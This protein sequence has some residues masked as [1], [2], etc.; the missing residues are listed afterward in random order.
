MTIKS[1]RIFSRRLRILLITVLLFI[2]IGLLYIWQKVYVYRTANRSVEIIDLRGKSFPELTHY[3]QSQS[4]KNGAV[5]AFSLLKQAM[6]PSNTDLHLL[7]HIIGDELYKQRG[8]EGIYEC[9]QDFRNAC[10]HSIVVGLYMEKAEAALPEISEIC[11]KA[12]GGSGAYTMCFHGLGHGVLAAVNYDM[13]QAVALCQKTGTPE[14]QYREAAECIGGAVMEIISGGSH[15]QKAWA[16]Q[17]KKY[18]DTADMLTPCSAEYIPD[19]AKSICYLYLT[20]LLFQR[21]GADLGNPDSKYFP[22]AFSYCNNLPV[23]DFANRDACYGGFGKE[24]IVLVQD[25]DIR[26][27]EQLTDAQFRKAISWC[28]MAGSAF[29]VDACLRAITQTLYWGGENDVQVAI[30]F[31]SAIAEIGA[32]NACFATL[33]GAVRFYNTGRPERI[34]AYCTQVPA[35][36][37]RDCQNL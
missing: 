36:Y 27:I 10:S 31:C 1:R 11:R 28:D 9:T 4:E 6:L 18:L 25:R 7:G 16:E 8:I 5:Y 3:F 33:T 24:F 22:Q 2:H 12:P 30:R 23:N 19:S 14:F 15:N 29:G 21:A 35:S 20:P 17:S 13:P 34:A 32:Q 26:N 37:Q